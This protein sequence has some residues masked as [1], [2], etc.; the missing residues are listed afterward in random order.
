[1]LVREQPAAKGAPPSQPFGFSVG[2][3][4]LSGGTV[5]VLDETTEKPFRFAL[6]RVS[7]GV[8]GLANAPDAK[9]AVRFACDA[10]AKGRLAYDGS[11]ALVP[12]STAGKLDLANLQVGAFAPYI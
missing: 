2:E 12:V 4:A 11:L 7:L 1:A 6:D 10:G 8:T 9:A 3:I 5:R